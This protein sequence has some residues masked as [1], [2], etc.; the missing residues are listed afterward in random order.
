[1]SIRNK[2]NFLCV[3]ATAYLI[4]SEINTIVQVSASQA[5]L[6]LAKYNSEDSEQNNVSTE[7]VEEFEPHP[8]IYCKDEEFLH[9]FISHDNKSQMI[10]VTWNRTKAGERAVLPNICSVD[11]GLPLRR[12]CY[13]FAQGTRWESYDNKTVLIDCRISMFCQSEAFEHYVIGSNGQLELHQNAW[14]RAKIGEFSSLRDICLQPNGL[15]LTRKCSYDSK[16]QRA[17]WA[18]VDN[19]KNFKCLQHTRQQVI[20]K[21]LNVLHENITTTNFLVRDMTTRRHT[22]TTLLNLL[23]LPKTKLLPADVQLTSEILKN[24]VTDSQDIELSS[25]VLKITHNLMSTD[26]SFIHT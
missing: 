26:R 3:L 5:K 2:M 14:K 17:R 16:A 11:N 6:K 9:K 12:R 1:M 18:A 7:R 19:L 4:L 24:I 8:H 22:A 23:Q 10:W 21:Q 13:R 20:S 25:D 15:H